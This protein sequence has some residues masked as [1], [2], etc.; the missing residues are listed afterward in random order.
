M[1][2]RNSQ[3]RGHVRMV[4]STGNRWQKYCLLSA[5]IGLVIWTIHLAWQPPRPMDLSWGHALLT[6]AVLVLVPACLSLV[7]P[8]IRGWAA[9]PWKAAVIGQ[10]P[11]AA[12]VWA[13]FAFPYGA[14]VWLSV[15]WAA[16]TWLL[17]IAGCAMAVDGFRTRRNAHF[18]YSLAAGLMYVAI[19]GTFIVFSHAGI[20]PLGFEP[21]IVFLTGMHFHYAGF[22]LPILTGLAVAEIEKEQR[23][24]PF[25]FLMRLGRFAE[26]GV[27]SGVPLLA[28]GINATQL[29][30]SPILEAVCVA[31]LVL[32]VVGGGLVH[33]ILAVRTSAPPSARALWAC[34]GM[35]LLFGAAFALLYGLRAWGI[36]PELT[37]PAMRAWHGTIMAI[38]FALAGTLGWCVASQKMLRRLR[39]GAR[40]LDPPA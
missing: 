37:I 28:L 3:P 12:M 11:A 36:A 7:A 31:W 9:W 32:G 25:P 20:R 34:A 10:L 18:R 35:S 4:R 1:I 40:E 21:I 23:L 15:P 19:G 5:G 2:Q 33:W 14:A 8:H 30:V 22:V 13:S 39:S 24:A 29:G 17:A 6:L 38:G 16:V 26:S 27:V